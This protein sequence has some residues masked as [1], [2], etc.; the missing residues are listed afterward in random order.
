MKQTYGRARTSCKG[1]TYWGLRDFLLLIIMMAIVLGLDPTTGSTFEISRGLVA[2][3]AS[4]QEYDYTEISGDTKIQVLGFQNFLNRVVNEN[5]QIFVKKLDVQI[6]GKQIQ[7][8]KAIFEPVQELSWDYQKEKIPNTAQ[9]YF[10]RKGQNIYHKKGQKYSASLTQLLPTGG[11]AKLEY[12]F[13]KDNNDLVEDRYEIDDNEYSAYMGVTITQPLLK[14]AGSKVT[15]SQIKIAKM[16]KKISR[17]NFRQKRQRELYRAVLSYWDL[18]SAQRRYLFHRQSLELARKLVKEVQNLIKGGKLPSSEIYDARSGLTLRETKLEKAKQRLFST[19]NKLQTFFSSRANMNERMYITNIEPQAE[20][21]GFDYTRALNRAYQNR[22]EYL[23]AN[24]KAKRAGVR[25]N[26]RKNQ[27]LPNL[28]LEA[29]YG[30][31]SL[32]VQPGKALSNSV[33]QDFPAWSVGLRLSFPITGEKSQ[34]K[35]LIARKKKEQARSELQSVRVDIVNE[36]SSNLNNVQSGLKQLKGHKQNVR[37][38]RKL[39][40]SEL[41]K[42]QAGKSYV[43][44]LLQREKDLN[45]ALKQRLRAK[46]EYMKSIAELKKAEGTIVDYFLLKD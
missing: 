4:V 10:D 31:N 3:N 30:S 15:R 43:R 2:E 40:N 25:V 45:Q 32:E 16:N 17:Q 23:R 28:D 24:K 44:R 33:E 26:Y 7:Q 42:L 1:T 21:N 29:S 34:S 20:E 12:T 27:N 11:E 41:K 38:K 14:D 46:V 5:K 37:Y 6:A 18:Y 9:Q 8:E 22:A 13:D 39:L 19:S 35:L 36:I